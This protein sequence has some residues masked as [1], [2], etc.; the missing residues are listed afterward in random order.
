MVCT[1]DMYVIQLKYKI[2]VK[3]I[4]CCLKIQSKLDILNDLLVPYNESI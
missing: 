2:E 3:K 4:I 1:L